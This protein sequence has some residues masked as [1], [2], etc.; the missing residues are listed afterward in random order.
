MASV[1]K[2]NSTFPL[3]SRLR[4]RWLLEVE[5]PVV[6]ETHGGEGRIFARCYSHIEKGIVFEKDK[7]KT[8]AL[9]QQRPT[10]SVYE[11]DCE[12]AIAKGAGSHLPVNFLDLD[13]YGSPWDALKGFFASDRPRPK[14]LAIV[15]NDGLC[16]FARIGSG[17]RNEV[18]RDAIE[19]YGN[20]EVF[21][22]Y[23]IIAKDMLKELAGGVGYE[24]TKWTGYHCGSRRQLTHY[25]AVLCK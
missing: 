19:E 10:W 1:Q 5:N 11:A 22:N 2:D 7:D 4:S 25:A 15:V 21:E 8:A 17:W 9:G 20:S 14:R 12:Y 6:M 3:K 23:L 13:P 18:L 24:L 16:Q